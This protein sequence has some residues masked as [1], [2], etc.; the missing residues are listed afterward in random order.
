MA[1]LRGSLSLPR[2]VL[3]GTLAVNFPVLLLM[4]GPSFFA[5]RVG[6]DEAVPY[7]FFMGF[8]L[9]WAWWS[10]AVPRWRLWAYERVSSTGD[11]HRAGIAAG[12]LWP[13]GSLFERS[14][15]TTQAQRSRREKLEH[16]FP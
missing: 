8:A 5:S 13:K 4:I 12:L 14:E 3:I 16:E 6:L 10:L 7:L 15:L 9:A 2:A 11:L 1:N